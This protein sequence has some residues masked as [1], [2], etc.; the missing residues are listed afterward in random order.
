MKVIMIS[1]STLYNSPGGDTIQI[2]MTAKHLRELG[3]EVDILTS[4]N[5]VDYEKYDLIHFF[6]IIRPDDIVHHLQKNRPYVISTIFVDYS[7]F[8]KTA[9]SG[10]S[11]LIF[12]LLNPYHIEYIKCIARFILRR[13]TLKSSYFLL[14]GQFRSI[15]HIARNAKLLLPNSHSE[16][17]RFQ[18][19][20]GDFPYKKVVNAVNPD[21]FNDSVIPDEAF[22]DHVIVVGRIEGIKNQLNVIKAMMNTEFQLTIIGKSSLNQKTYYQAC[23]KL[24]EGY[25]NIHF[26]EEQVDHRRLASIYK[27]AKVHVLASWFETTGLVS[28][29][30][31]LMG[32]NVVVTRKGD[33]EEYFENM[34]F[35]CEPDNV[36]SIRDAIH[37]AYHTSP[38]ENLK[39]FIRTNY[40]WDQTAQQTFEA[41]QA[42]LCSSF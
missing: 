25:A 7:E 38:K 6:N 1:R 12:K 30:A 17:R 14:N 10:I 16:Y 22:R 29:E 40:T 20:F 33:T 35:Y 26:L 13:D 42:A 32:C 31:G 39:S 15:L 3:V 4:E 41:Y 9:R 8:D 21:I 18:K 11:G 34:A 24:A 27:A 19:A 2:H 23:R 28:L 36:D 5:N 37:K